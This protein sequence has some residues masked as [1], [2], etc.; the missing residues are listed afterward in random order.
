MQCSAGIL[1][2]FLATD[3]RAA[4]FGQPALP[5]ALAAKPSG[6]L[7]PVPRCHRWLAPEV[8]A[9][10]PATLESDVYSMGV[11]LWVRRLPL[12]PSQVESSSYSFPPQDLDCLVLAS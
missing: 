2:S 3:C 6:S 4:T 11:I 12:L 10:Q 8:L 7:R 9:G 5:H 1:T